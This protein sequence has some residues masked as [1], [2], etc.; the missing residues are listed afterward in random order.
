MVM[1][2]GKNGGWINE[3][4]S[5]S[6]IWGFGQSTAG[7]EKENWGVVKGISRT[8]VVSETQRKT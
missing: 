8:T 1:I 5:N 2:T 7:I 6:K 4:Y 3:Y